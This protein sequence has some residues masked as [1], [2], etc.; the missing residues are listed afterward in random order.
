VNKARDLSVQ[1]WLLEQLVLKYFDL[2]LTGLTGSTTTID[3]E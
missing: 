1:P 2:G 3:T